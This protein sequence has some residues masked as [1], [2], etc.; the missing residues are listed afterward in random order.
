MRRATRNGPPPGPGAPSPNS[1]EEA[2][3]AVFHGLKVFGGDSPRVEAAGRIADGQG[4]VLE[5]LAVETAG[6]AYE[7]LLT[8]ECRPSGMQAAL[9]LLGCK[10]HAKSG[11]K[12]ALELEWT[13]KWNQWFCG[14]WLCEG[15]APPPFRP[16]PAHALLLRA[17]TAT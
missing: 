1:V 7:S 9:L 17:S 11:T 10:P 16:A 14:W 4:D 6:R 5:F 2:P 13:S 8:L 15:E 3:A 12:L